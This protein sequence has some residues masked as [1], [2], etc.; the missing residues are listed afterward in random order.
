MICHVAPPSKSFLV[1]QAMVLH[2][3][4]NKALEKAPR[5]VRRIIIAV[6]GSPRGWGFP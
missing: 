6:G 5:L 3:M 1:Q 2:G 4:R